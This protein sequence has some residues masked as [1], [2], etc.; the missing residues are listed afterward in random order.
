MLQI[1]SGEEKV[2]N[3]ADELIKEEGADPQGIKQAYPVE[4]LNGLQS[5]NLPPSKLC[6]KIGSPIMILRNLAPEEGVCNGIRAIVIKTN[7]WV[8]E[9]KLLTGDRTGMCHAQMSQTYLQ[10]ANVI[11]VL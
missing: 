10:I 3:S 8:L 6:L 2:F 1:F 4:Y 9:A 7:H 5:G 11:I